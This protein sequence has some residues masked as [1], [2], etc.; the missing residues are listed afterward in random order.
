MVDDGD[1]TVFEM[2]RASFSWKEQQDDD[3]EA[4]QNTL[5]TDNHVHIEEFTPFSLKDVNMFVE[6]VANIIFHFFYK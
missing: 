4:R 3:A 2:E 1:N 6:K 5:D